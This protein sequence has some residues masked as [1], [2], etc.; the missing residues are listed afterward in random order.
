MF[1]D[2]PDAEDWDGV[3]TILGAQRVLAANILHTDD[4]TPTTLT[5]S[6]GLGVPVKLLHESLGHV[7]TV[8]LKTGQLYRGKL[9][10]GALIHNPCRV[11]TVLTPRSITQRRT[12]SILH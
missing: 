12:T 4:H 1:P 3:C 5:M 7:I 10:E 11:H 8:E 9:A 6:S 2:S